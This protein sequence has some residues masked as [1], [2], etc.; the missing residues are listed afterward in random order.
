LKVCKSA[1][2]RAVTRAEKIAFDL[3]LRLIENQRRT[4][5]IPSLFRP[6]GSTQPFVKYLTFQLTGSAR[7]IFLTIYNYYGF[8]LV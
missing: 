2:S 5:T 4:K 8:G 7:N 1:V 3:K 6:A